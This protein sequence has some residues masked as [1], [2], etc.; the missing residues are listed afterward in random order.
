MTLAHC[1]PIAWPIPCYTL[2]NLARNTHLG[3]VVIPG[4]QHLTRFV[5][6]TYTRWSTL[7]R[8]A[9]PLTGRC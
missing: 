8:I 4:T 1:T 2:A 9:K 3:T 5:V 6:G 7:P